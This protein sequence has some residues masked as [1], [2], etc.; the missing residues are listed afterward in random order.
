MHAPP[1]VFI[2]SLTPKLRTDCE[3]S[4]SHMD[5]R[6]D[7]AGTVYSVFTTPYTVSIDGASSI[8]PDT[9]CKAGKHKS[10]R[11]YAAYSRRISHAFCAFTRGIR[12]KVIHVGVKEKTEKIGLNL[13]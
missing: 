3:K 12:I 5:A 7:S 6:C 1:G 2:K 10:Q 9:I 4:S 11:R 8:V 13:R